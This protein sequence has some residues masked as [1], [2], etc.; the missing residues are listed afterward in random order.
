MPTFD[1]LVMVLTRCKN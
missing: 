1:R